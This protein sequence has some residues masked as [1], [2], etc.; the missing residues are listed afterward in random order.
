[1]RAV[2]TLTFI[3][4]AVLSTQ[5]AEAG[6]TGLK[7][8][9]SKKDVDLAN[10][11]LYFRI[12]RPADSAEIKVYSTEG[13]LLVERTKLYDGAR[14]GTRLSITWPELLGQDS[15]NFRIELKV[16]DVDE[17]WIGWEVIRF[18]LE[19]PH[20]EVVFETAKWDIRPSEAPKLDDALKILIPA[21]KKHGKLMDCK[22]YVAGHTDTVGSLA[23][24]RELSNRR[25]R[26]IANY[27]ASHGVQGIPIMAR[28][29]GEELL[30]VETGDNVAEARNRR[31]L[32]IL[33]TFPPE[34]SGP[35]SWQKV[36]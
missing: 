30:A 11:T 31:A 35:G 4:C 23:D 24:N 12:N 34:M 6:R 9:I 36:K 19:I 25:A 17:Y 27:F 8:S 15:E 16:T 1:M 33:A 32:Y 28:G 5:M 10:R 3:L 22:L 21:I 18:Y 7:L 2:W 20:E 29:F 13:R 26:S 14:P